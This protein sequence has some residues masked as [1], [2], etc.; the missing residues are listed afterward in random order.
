MLAR[1]CTHNEVPKF[2]VRPKEG[3]IAAASTS[4]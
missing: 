1:T 2:M 3:D 4:R